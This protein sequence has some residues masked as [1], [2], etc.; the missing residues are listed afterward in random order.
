MNKK[1]TFTIKEVLG[2]RITKVILKI[3]NNDNLEN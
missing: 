1:L 2:R 3:E